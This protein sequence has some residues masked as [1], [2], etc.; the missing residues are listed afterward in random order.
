MIAFLI[1]IGLLVAAAVLVVGF[2]VAFI[3]AAFRYRNGTLT[4][5]ELEISSN[6]VKKHIR[7]KLENWKRQPLWTDSL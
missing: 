6:K 4:K 1:L 2:L 5:E 7:K 3:V